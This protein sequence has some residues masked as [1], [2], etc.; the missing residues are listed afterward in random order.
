MRIHR[1]IAAFAA[2]N[3]AATAIEY[4]LIVGLIAVAGVGAF[5]ALGDSV[6]GAWGNIAT[7]A[8]T[9]M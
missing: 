7:A 4:G 1:G 9:N 2:N 5:S 6:H 8:K 3:R